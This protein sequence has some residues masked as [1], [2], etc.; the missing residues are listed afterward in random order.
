[1]Q[2]NY[3]TNESVMEQITTLL[4]LEDEKFNAIYDKLMEEMDKTFAGPG[5]RDDIRKSMENLPMGDID[6]ERMAIEEEIKNVEKMDISENKKKFLAYV[7]QKSF[8]ITLEVAENPRKKIKVGIERIHENAVIPSYA[9]PTDHCCDIYAIE[10]CTIKPHETKII[11]TGLKFD[12]PAGYVI[13]LYPRSGMSYKTKIR[14]ANSVG[15]IDHTYHKELGVIAENTSGVSYEIKKGD[16]I[17]QIAIE[18]SPMFD[19]EERE[20]S[21]T[22]RGGFG[23]TG[24]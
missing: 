23:S 16:R 10:D 18:E 24:K 2:S 4:E 22:E 1:M 21:D 15:I 11:P 19:F 3:L 7:L 6:E 5:I 9:N 12:M 8:D 20:V 13:K 14:I 17:A